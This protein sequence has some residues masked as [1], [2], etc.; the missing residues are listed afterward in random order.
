MISGDPG[1]VIAFLKQI[2]HFM[3]VSVLR[4]RLPGRR[5]EGHED[6]E[7]DDDVGGS[8]ERLCG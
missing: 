1:G 6:F 8:G 4:L 2:Y 7:R 3:A 5:Q